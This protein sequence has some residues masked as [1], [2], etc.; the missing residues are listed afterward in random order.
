MIRGNCGDGGFSQNALGYV[1][2]GR[3]CLLFLI[4]YLIKTP[5]VCTI[6]HEAHCLRAE[7]EMAS[8]VSF[9]KLSSC[10]SRSDTFTMLTSSALCFRRVPLSPF[11]ELQNGPC[12]L[13]H[14]CNIAD[15]PIFAFSLFNFC[16][17][18][19]PGEMIF[20]CN[21]QLLIR[22]NKYKSYFKRKEC[23]CLVIMVQV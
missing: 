17:C 21:G 13:Q 15:T 1:M 5:S 8:S 18:C 7:G 11:T 16:S 14:A 10:Q 3:M 12:D 20:K 2:K 23:I 9:W 4:A 22:P 6:Q 19:F